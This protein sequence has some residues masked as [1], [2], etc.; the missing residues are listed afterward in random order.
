MSIETTIENINNIYNNIDLQVQRIKTNV[1]TSI[2]TVITR[3][4]LTS[5]GNETIEDLPSLI[6]SIETYKSYPNGTS[7]ELISTIIYPTCICYGKGIWIVGS[8]SSVPI[9]SRDGKNWSEISL[10]A[11]LPYITYNDGMWVA[12]TST[13][14]FIYYSTDGI[15]WSLG[16]LT[17]LTNSDSVVSIEYGNYMWILQTMT[18]MYYSTDGI[19]WSNCDLSN[20]NN[21]GLPNSFTFIWNSAGNQNNIMTC[22]YDNGVWVSLSNYGIIYSNDGITWYES[23]IISSNSIG[24]LSDGIMFANGIWVTGFNKNVLYSTDGMTWIHSNLTF[25]YYCSI[26]FNNNIWMLSDCTTGRISYS[27][28]GMTWT[29]II[30]NAELNFIMYHGD[31]WYHCSF[32]LNR[33]INAKYS[34]DSITWSKVSGST[35]TPY[36]IGYNCGIYI[37]LSDNALC[38][39]Y[40]G[41]NF[42]DFDDENLLLENITL[43][44]NTILPQSFYKNGV[45]LISIGNKLFSSTCWEL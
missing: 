25:S 26:N 35:Y 6:N 28:D 37:G 18:T 44:S 15:N 7:W 22:H 8:T 30:N 45:W 12:A 29:S 3:G 10:S 24:T 19:N 39:S 21:F 17:P 32:Y 31:K 16:N 20:L 34:L 1:E 23:N 41:I 38:Y 43:S 9:Y 36:I 2:D 13:T 27:T 14:N 40:D 4:N 33:D 5:S 42:I 11:Y